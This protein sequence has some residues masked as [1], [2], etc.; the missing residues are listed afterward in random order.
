MKII[1]V[2]LPEFNMAQAFKEAMEEACH[3]KYNND[4]ELTFVNVSLKVTEDV[5]WSKKDYTVTGVTQTYTFN[6][7]YSGG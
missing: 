6:F 2:T 5:D 7:S 4:Y 1:S 3:T